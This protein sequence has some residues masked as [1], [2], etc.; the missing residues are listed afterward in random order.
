MHA[1]RRARAHAGKQA[2]R[3]EQRNTRTAPCFHPQAC[4]SSRHFY[5]RPLVLL[6]QRAPPP[7]VGSGRPSCPCPPC[8]PHPS[9]L[10]PFCARH[11]PGAPRPRTEPA[12]GPRAAR[13]PG[14]GPTSLA[15]HRRTAPPRRP[16]RLR[17]QPPRP[18]P[19][20]LPRR[21]ISDARLEGRPRRRSFHRCQS[22]R[23]RGGSQRPRAAAEGRGRA[24]HDRVRGGGGCEGGEG[25]A[26]AGTPR[27]GGAEAAPGRDTTG[28]VG[29]QPQ[30]CAPRPHLT[31]LGPLALL[32]S[33]AQHTLRARQDTPG[34]Q[35]PPR[36]SPAREGWAEF[37]RCLPCA[38]PLPSSCPPLSLLALCA[39]AAFE[40]VETGR[41]RMYD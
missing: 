15:P 31:R 32:C 25:G 12:L 26:L 20:R 17:H 28:C 13:A 27:G 7:P 37:C 10:G 6:P 9:S 33:L 14:S 38:R 11:T 22:Q 35:S 23:R 2:R 4:Q 16:L 21:A 40:G 3:H 30:R 41:A 1:R 36:A 39:V 34:R 18:V 29:M 19:E 24:A 5:P 8:R